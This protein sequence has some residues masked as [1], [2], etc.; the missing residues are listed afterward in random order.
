[1]P[2]QSFVV[3]P[4]YSTVTQTVPKGIFTHL[5]LSLF[6]TETCPSFVPKSHH[7]RILPARDPDKMAASINGE[8]KDPH[9][10]ERIL[11]L[12]KSPY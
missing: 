3:P 8:S 12:R 6:S 9:G 5:L 1:M 10:R 7:L 4:R 2:F 11:F